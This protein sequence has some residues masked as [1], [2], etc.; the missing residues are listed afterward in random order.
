[1][2]RGLALNVRTVIDIK[3]IVTALL[4]YVQN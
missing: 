1:M 4:K 2:S 3:R